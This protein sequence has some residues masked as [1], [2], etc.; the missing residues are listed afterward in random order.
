MSMDR[1]QFVKLT[2]VGAS[3]AL[4]TNAAAGEQSTLEPTAETFEFVGVS[5]EVRLVV[6]SDDPTN[7]DRGITLSGVEPPL[8]VEGT[9]PGDGTWSSAPTTVTETELI[10]G[11]RNFNEQND[12]D[13]GKLLE[14]ILDDTPEE[15]VATLLENL[16]VE[17]LLANS[18]G[19]ELF[20]IIADI[21]DALDLDAGQGEDIINAIDDGTGLLPDSVLTIDVPSIVEI[22]E[23]DPALDNFL[24][25]ISGFGLGDGAADKLLAGDVPRQERANLLQELLEKVGPVIDSLP[26]DLISAIGID[27]PDI[28]T[29]NDATDLVELVSWLLE[30]LTKIQNSNLGGSSASLQELEASVSDDPD[31]AEV[32]QALAELEAQQQTV[33]ADGGTD[34]QQDDTVGTSQDS[35]PSL[36]D[37]LLATSSVTE[38]D[39]EI[40]TI[41]QEIRNQ[42]FDAVFGSGDGSNQDQDTLK[43]LLDLLEQQLT[44]DVTIE[45]ISGDY[46]HDSGLMT[47]PVGENNVSLDSS[48]QNGL[49]SF[50]QDLIDALDNSSDDGNTDPGLIDEILDAINPDDFQPLID[51]LLDELKAQNLIDLP[52]LQAG[53]T[54]GTSG[55]FDGS[56]TIEDG[57]AGGSVQFV[58]N[59]FTIGYDKLITDIE[60]IDVATALGNVEIT[61]FDLKTD[62]VDN[63]ADSAWNDISATL[64]T[65]LQSFAQDGGGFQNNPVAF[66][67]NNIS[68]VSD[69]PTFLNDTAASAA[70]NITPEVLLTD[71]ATATDVDGVVTL[72][73]NFAPSAFTDSAGRHAVEATFTIVGKPGEMA[74]GLVPQDNDGDGRFE[75]FRGTGEVGVLDTQALFNAL[76]DGSAQQTPRAFNFSQSSA[77]DEVSILDVAAHWKTHVAEE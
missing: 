30:T 52:T 5:E 65:E 59:E 2:G 58:E 34:S 67:E 57:P 33:S 18:D 9:A 45:Q 51:E 75:S 35:D 31:Q 7:P 1:R 23:Q 3:G 71:I 38:L 61:N 53:L 48:F 49:I 12:V 32:V 46:D 43:I 28:P 55:S 64:G 56:F 16:S 70:Q 42:G 44:L 13:L 76:K 17:S 6:N 4:A 27:I 69:F 73:T 22:L 39:N 10:E 41:A 77:E 68:G 63:I 50:I 15:L 72:V 19:A 62:V 29:L 20:R 24:I 37:R 40:D 60:N 8:D 21:I 66:L 26:S 11:L 14:D 74:G 25:T 47:A 54:T 36:I